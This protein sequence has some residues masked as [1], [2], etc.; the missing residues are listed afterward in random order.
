M[1]LQVFCVWSSP[2]HT[3]STQLQSPALW[4]TP[5][6][7]PPPLHTNRRPSPIPPCC[8]HHRTTAAVKGIE[9]LRTLELS[10]NPIGAEGAKAFAEVIKYDSQVRGAAPGVRRWRGVRGG[11]WCGASASVCSVVPLRSGQCVQWRCQ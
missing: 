9:A 8:T 10:Y 3:P 1:G 7:P 4:D 11:A 2:P 5:V 6:P